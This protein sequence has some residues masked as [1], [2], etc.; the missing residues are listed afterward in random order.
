MSKKRVINISPWGMDVK[1]AFSSG[2]IVLSF[3]EYRHEID[4]VI[5]VRVNIDVTWVEYIRR[6]LTV[7]VL[8][9]MQKRIN[10]AYEQ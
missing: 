6:Q 8:E 7:G 3:E 1:Y 2:K 10:Q 9:P 5:E 4:T